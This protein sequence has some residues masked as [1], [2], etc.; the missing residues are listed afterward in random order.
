M[1]SGG[2]EPAG[3]G[4]GQDQDQDQDQ[5]TATAN[6]SVSKLTNGRDL[7]LKEPL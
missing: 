5:K 3:Q 6:G 2:V 4:L 1:L 7:F